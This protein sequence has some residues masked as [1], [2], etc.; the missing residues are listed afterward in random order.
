MGIS[1]YG[2]INGGLQPRAA[3]TAE[4][5]HIGVSAMDASDRSKSLKG[6]VRRFFRETLPHRQVLTDYLKI[7]KLQLIVVDSH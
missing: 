2:F 5:F 7:P 3:L 4:Q 6:T 1:S